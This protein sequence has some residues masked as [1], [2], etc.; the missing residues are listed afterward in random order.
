MQS[1]SDETIAS[2]CDT[3]SSNCYTQLRLLGQNRHNGKC[4]EIIK[5]FRYAFKK[6]GYVNH[7][8]K[9]NSLN[10]KLALEDLKKKIKKDFPDFEVNLLRD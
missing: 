6:V 7:L 2:N 10:A 8:G 3:Y 4:P 5:D 9:E 1:L